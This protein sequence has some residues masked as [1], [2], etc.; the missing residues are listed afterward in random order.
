MMKGKFNIKGLDVVYFIYESDHKDPKMD[1]IILIHGG[2][3]AT[4]NYMQPMK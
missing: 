2:P 3:A 1:P 4:H